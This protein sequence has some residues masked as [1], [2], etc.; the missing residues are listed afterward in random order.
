MKCT[1]KYFFNIILVCAGLAAN[2]QESEA[3][4]MPRRQMFVR[5]GCDLSRFALP[6]VGDVGSH[7]ME[8]SLDGELHYNWFPVVEVG[9]QWIKHN[10]DSLNYKM[11]GVYGRIGFDYNVLKY[12]HRLDRDIFY[13]G[14]RM[15]HCTFS[16]ELPRV[17]MH[18]GTIG[19]VEDGIESRKLSATWGELVVGAKA[20]IFKNL[21]LGVAARAKA[22]FAHTSYDNMTPYIVPGFGKGY[23]QFTGGFTYSIMFAIP[24]RSAGSDGYAVE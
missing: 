1:L 21:Y 15:A 16:H 20:E 6:L 7:G 23:Y 10:T 24:I 14:V 13:L 17:V 8:F 2:A 9:S 11:D 3:D 5:A 22:M 19:D 12:Q 18:S 4:D